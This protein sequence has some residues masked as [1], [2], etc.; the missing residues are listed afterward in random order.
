M[1]VYIDIVFLINVYF[2]FILLLVT[3]LILKRNVSLKRIFLGSIVGGFT[4]V[5][6]FFELNNLLL[7]IYKI[8][9]SIF[10]I[11]CT[12]SYK[13]F[14]YF[15]NNLIYLYIT[16]FVLGGFLYLIELEFSISNMFFIGIF[17]FIILYF[18]LRN[19]NK[20]KYNY[21]NYLK[22]IVKYKDKVLNLVGYID[23]GN[24]L[25]DQYKNRPISLIYLVDFEYDYK[26]II[27]VPY[28][29]AS[30]SSILKCLKVDKLIIDNKECSGLIGFMD[31]K[32]KIDGVD[33][34]LNSKYIG[35]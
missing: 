25:S 28:E 22:V 23:S 20:L 32:I 30:G 35:G 34:I 18:Y 2:D 11:I 16:S 5:L 7:F 1:K 9:F 8:I 24:K 31:K 26:D 13:D 12:F 4:I 15:I 3:S 33:I 19:L 29:T 14:Y 27:L 17:S 10:M 21:N 6:L